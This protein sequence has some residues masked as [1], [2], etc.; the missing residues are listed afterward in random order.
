MKPS[1]PTLG[2][3][4]RALTAG[5]WTLLWH[6]ASQLLRLAGN[7]V[8]TRLLV[9]EMF[10]IMTIATTVAVVLGMLSDIGLRQN[11]I[12][13]RRG[14][15][16]AF[17]DTAWTVQ[18]VRGVL[19]FVA[20]L[21]TAALAALA[22]RAGVWPEGSTYAA[23]ELPLV[24][25]LTGLSAAIYGFQS[26]KMATADRHFQ[27]KRLLVT[28]FAGQAAGLATMVVWGWLSPSIWALVAA[29]WVAA[30]TTVVLSHAWLD[31]H[32]NRMRWE[33]AALAE[34]SGF[35][36][37]VFLS[38]AL[39]VLA[40]NGD[41]ILLGGSIAVAE[42][43]VYSIA[44]LLLGAIESG[45]GRLQ[46]SVA[47]PVLGA[48]ARDEPARLSEAYYRIR[49]PLDCVLFFVAGLLFKAGDAL[50]ALL[51]DTRYAG[52]GGM[53]EILSLSILMWRYRIDE[54]AY[55]ALGKTRYLAFLNGLRCL[56]LFVAVPVLFAI[57]STRYA[58]FGIAVHAYVAIPCFI[59]LSARLGLTQAKKE[60]IALPCLVLGYALGALL[61]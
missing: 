27:Q 7:L 6:V 21:G 49:V 24:L 47:L 53:L 41:R 10:G 33:K 54:Q 3:R 32:D 61:G 5:A 38:S 14:D 28:E 52:A 50:V 9:P 17:L 57:G 37:W 15:D 59:Y 58:V 51:Y 2:L 18:I 19:L 40:A 12:Q 22:E 46:T 23:P 35:G 11:I 45:F 4:S 13:S 48:I 60:V 16:A 55:L 20:A 8:M 36:R 56:S 31:G 43:G 29:G 30:A 25:A 39:G 34:L 1:S 42:F 44:V 26:T